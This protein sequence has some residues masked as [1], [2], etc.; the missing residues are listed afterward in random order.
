MENK[1]FYKIDP[2]TNTEK[3]LVA[4]KPD[5]SLPKARPIRNS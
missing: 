5:Y 4:F 2:T 1:V 3:P